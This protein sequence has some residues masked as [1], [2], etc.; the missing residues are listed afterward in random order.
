MC[1]IEQI[2]SIDEVKA[3]IVQA[4]QIFP[5][6]E[7]NTLLMPE[8]HM[9]LWTLFS[10]LVICKSVLKYWNWCGPII[11]AQQTLKKKE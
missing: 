11:I 1:N 9:K 7:I 3:S 5:E 4:K 8:N 6:I 2:S 10:L